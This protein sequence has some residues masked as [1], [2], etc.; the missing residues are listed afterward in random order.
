MEWG[1]NVD[2]GSVIMHVQ[3]S[4]SLGTG[5]A[6]FANN[7]A[8]NPEVRGMPTGDF[9]VELW[10]R[11][12]A[13]PEGTVSNAFQTLVSYATHTEPAS[14]GGACESPTLRRFLE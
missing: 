3:G 2:P 12:P 14:A 13:H 1:V 11:T 8:F 6:A 9:S 4:S 7:Y 10:A 5:A